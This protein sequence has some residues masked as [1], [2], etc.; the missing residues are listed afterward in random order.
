M[1]FV[2]AVCF[3]LNRRW[4]TVLGN[5]VWHLA[6]GSAWH[7]QCPSSWFYQCSCYF[8]LCLHLVLV[9]QPLQSAITLN[10]VKEKSL[11]N[12]NVHRCHDGLLVFTL[13]LGTSQEY[14]VMDTRPACHMVCLFTFS[15]S[16]YK[17]ML[18]GNRV[19]CV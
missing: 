13:Q 11:P 18:P 17:L 3:C 6:D 4:D 7:V 19:K 15:L 8:A 10:L 14:S 9:Q 2:V 5:R 1:S 16:W 12:H